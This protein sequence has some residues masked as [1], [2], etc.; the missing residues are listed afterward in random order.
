M[1]NPTS[2]AT[3]ADLQRKVSENFT[4]IVSAV[5]GDFALIAEMRETLK[6]NTAYLRK[7]EQLTRLSDGLLNKSPQIAQ[8]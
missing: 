5:C 2:A 7:C 8:T 1:F 6:R 3:T 4:D